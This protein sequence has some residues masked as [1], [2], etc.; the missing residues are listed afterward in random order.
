MFRNKKQHCKLFLQKPSPVLNHLCIQSSFISHHWPSISNAWPIHG[1]FITHFGTLQKM[2]IFCVSSQLQFVSEARYSYSNKLNTNV[3]SV[4]WTIYYTWRVCNEIN[5]EENDKKLREGERWK[6]LMRCEWQLSMELICWDL[7]DRTHFSHLPLFW[8]VFLSF[9]ILNLLRA[10]RHA[11]GDESDIRS[12]LH[13]GMGTQRNTWK[14]YSR[15][16]SRS[17]SSNGKLHVFF[18]IPTFSSKI[19]HS[20]FIHFSLHYVSLIFFHAS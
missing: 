2:D 18:Q 14:Q 4:I 6:V 5:I 16:H 7:L 19:T 3:V 15:N 10:W 20:L 11:L 8:H 13:H 9:I 17:L 12:R 1:L